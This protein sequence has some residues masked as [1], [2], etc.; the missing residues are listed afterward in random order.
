MRAIGLLFLVSC[1][2]R[3]E[4]LVDDDI[5]TD[6]DGSQFDGARVAPGMLTFVE[7]DDCP[8][9]WTQWD[10]AT[11]RALVGANDGA[12]VGDT[13]GD[14]LSDHVPGDHAHGIT[15][16]VE[17]ASAGVSGIQGCCNASPGEEGIYPVTGT[18][19]ARENRLPT[20]ALRVCRRDGDAATSPSEDAFPTGAVAFFDRLSCPD[21][22][23]A[24]AQGAGRMAVGLTMFGD[25]LETVGT[26]LADGEDR[27]H[28][29]AVTGSVAVPVNSIAGSSGGS[30]YAAAGAHQLTGGTSDAAT[31]GLPLVAALLCVR[32]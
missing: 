32:N 10:P 11:G 3:F 7:T 13:V 28:S 21:Q 17:V 26:P 24:I 22:W 16:Q 2:P 31:S 25:P 1:S 27:T 29:H 12:T 14:A 23:T 20:I 8:E 6:S 5:R 19:D 15:A 30:Q 4:P 9:L 18:G